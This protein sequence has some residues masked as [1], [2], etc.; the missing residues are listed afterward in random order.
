MPKKKPAELAFCGF[1]TSLA[2]QAGNLAEMVTPPI[3]SEG[4]INKQSTKFVFL[5]TR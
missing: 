4:R 1:L 3:T 2:G 5:N